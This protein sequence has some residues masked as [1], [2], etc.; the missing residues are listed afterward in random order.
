LWMKDLHSALYS[1][2]AVPYE[3]DEH[4]ARKY[5]TPAGAKR[6]P[7]KPLR[8]RAVGDLNIRFIFD[9]LMGNTDRGMNDHNNFVYGG[10]D[11][12]TRC[13]PEPEDERIKGPAKYAFIDHGSSFYSRK[14][15]EENPFTGNLSDIL[16]CRYRRS[17]Y[18]T[19]KR[20]VPPPGSTDK[21][22]LV[23]A[24]RPKLPKNLFRIVSIHTFA[25]TQ[26][27]L[28]KVVT[29]MEECVAKYGVEKV[30]SLPEYWEV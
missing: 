24:I 10:C 25:Q 16:I 12:T 4:F 29:V 20:F 11:S 28:E 19:L 5:Y 22:P 18:D 7:P 6:W 21:E 13:A 30:F 2:L 14:E 17:T 27:R 9:F 3:F 1:T 15:P 23:S 8:L 26:V